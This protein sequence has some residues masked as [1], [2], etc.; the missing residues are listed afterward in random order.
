MRITVFAVL[1]AAVPLSAGTAAEKGKR[2]STMKD[3]P[4][5]RATRAEARSRVLTTEICRG[6]GVEGQKKA[7]PSK[8][9]GRNLRQFRGRGTTISGSVAPLPLTSRAEAQVDFLNRQTV[10]QQQRLQFQQQTQFEINQ[11]RN[12]L[13]RGNEL[14]RGYLFR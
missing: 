2:G 4:T 13:Q 11:L 10:Q 5:E 9:S 6:C 7:R 8:F 12:E 1:L 14:H 3:T